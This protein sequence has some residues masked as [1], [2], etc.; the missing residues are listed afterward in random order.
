MKLNLLT[1]RY[2]FFSL[3]GI[4]RWTCL[5]ESPSWPHSSK[6]LRWRDFDIINTQTMASRTIIQN[7]YI[8]I[9]IWSNLLME[10]YFSSMA[11][12]RAPRRIRLLLVII[13]I[14]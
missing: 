13:I 2:L 7:N 1:V 10:T 3:G 6:E 12:G 14:I 9:H 4:I 8:Y 11:A 5:S